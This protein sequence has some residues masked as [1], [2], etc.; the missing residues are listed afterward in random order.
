MTTRG[1]AKG[2][3]ATGFKWVLLRLLEFYYTKKEATILN[4][5][6]AN[7]HQ[8]FEDVRQRRSFRCKLIFETVFSRSILE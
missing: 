6:Y 3:V 2:G 8:L 1:I 7:R 4:G 5:C